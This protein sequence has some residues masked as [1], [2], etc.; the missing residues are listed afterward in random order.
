MLEKLE[1]K[2]KFGGGGLNTF[3][4]IGKEYFLVKFIHKVPLLHPSAFSSR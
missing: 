4:G 3:N 1:M 2:F